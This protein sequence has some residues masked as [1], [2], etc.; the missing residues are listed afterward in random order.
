MNI[1]ERVQIAIL[2]KYYGKG[3][4]VDVSGSEMVHENT[5]LSLD[6]TKIRLFF[7]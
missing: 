5:L 1:E 6:V 3:K 4:V 7:I 2:V